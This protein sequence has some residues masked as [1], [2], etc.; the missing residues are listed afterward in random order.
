MLSSLI[1]VFREVLEAALVIGIVCAVTRGVNRRGLAVL[2]GIILG[3]AGAGLVAVFAD[4]VAEMAEGMGQEL[5]NASILLAVVLMLAWHN[6]WMSVHGAELAGEA[7]K[8]GESVRQ[9]IE[10]ITVLVTLVGLAV[11]REGAEVVLFLYGIA[12]SGSTAGGM[13]VGSGIGLLTGTLV[14]FALYGGLIRIPMRYFFSVTAI[15]LMLLAAG[16]ASQA[17]K[18][19]I[20]GDFIPAWGYGLWDSSALIANGSLL[21]QI[22]GTLVGYDAQP[23]GMQL[24]FYGVTLVTIISGMKLVKLRK[25]RKQMLA[26]QTQGTPL[27]T[28]LVL[29]ISSLV[30]LSAATPV[31]A[32][33]AAKV[34]SPIIEYGETEIEFRGGYVEDD[35]HPEDGE[36]QYKVAVGHGIMSRW[37]T[38]IVFEYET[39]PGETLN[40]EAVEWENIIQLTE[41]GQYFLDMGIFAEYVHKRDGDAAA[42]VEIGPMFQYEH[43]PA[44][45]NLNTIFEREVG[46]GAESPTELTYG[47]QVKW[48]GNERFEPGLQAF[49]ELGEWDDWVSSNQQEHNLGPAFFG[50]VKQGDYS[51]KY[52]AGWLFGLTSATPDNTI[53]FE[54]ELEY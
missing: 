13:A 25:E 9:G 40:L 48:R 8:A 51:V 46:D 1:I 11:L 54:L 45:F 32:G 2:V 6:I 18:Y 28:G 4:A 30:L 27:I 20:Q 50:K 3:V 49:G 52:S 5:F 44:V 23:A 43:G 15:M 41:P 14:G 37:F 35:D 10:P 34:Y 24:V 19:L 31:Q 39:G 17:A 42:K 12:A 38:E 33:P 21:G 22:L 47:F 53:R 7:T 29:V 36:Q 16:M 26:G